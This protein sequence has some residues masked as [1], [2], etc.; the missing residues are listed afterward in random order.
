MAA[1]R[2]GGTQRDA[3]QR[4]ATQRDALCMARLESGCLGGANLSPFGL[5]I[6]AS[7]QSVNLSLGPAVWLAR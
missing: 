7:A 3:T 1:E 2:T 6:G 4:A 5:L